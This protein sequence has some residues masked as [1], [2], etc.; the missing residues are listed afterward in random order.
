MYD[1]PDDAV[2]ADDLECTKGG[3]TTRRLWLDA[4]DERFAERDDDTIDK[5][6][7]ISDRDSSGDVLLEA[8]SAE[9]ERENVGR[10][11]S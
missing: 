2:E 11:S 3:G 4:T 7:V 9:L 5:R 6:F 1:D 8:D 10:E